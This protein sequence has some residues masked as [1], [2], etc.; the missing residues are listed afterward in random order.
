MQAGKWRQALSL[1]RETDD[2]F[3]EAHAQIHDAETKLVA[4]LLRGDSA[5]KLSALDLVALADEASGLLTAAD[6]DAT[7]APVLVDKLLALD[8]PARAEPILQHLFDHAGT[9]EQ[10]A[11]LGVR[12]AGL[13][14]DRGDWKD[15][16]GVL[17]HSDDSGLASSLVTRR[18]LL[19]AR[20]LVASGKSADALGVLSGV[21]GEEAVELQAKILE[22]RHEWAAA[23]KLLESLTGAAAFASKPDQAQRDLILRLA[24]D[25]SQAGDMAALHRLRGT[26]GAHM[27]TGPGA[28]LFAVLTQDPIQA[29]G[30]LPRSGHELDA[31][32]ALPASLATR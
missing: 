6:A 29:V 1:L 27:A 5:Q 4:A 11:E 14:A 3:P 13:M 18:G 30:D 7:L 21:Q 20:L 16:L 22:D 31:V 25:E 15:A 23:S 26:Q 19:R 9:P 2:L 12:L 28:E 8:L 17:G 10:R 24:N 32:R